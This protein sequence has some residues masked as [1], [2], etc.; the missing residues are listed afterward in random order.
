MIDIL[1]VLKLIALIQ[2]QMIDSVS[3]MLIFFR[4]CLG[5]LRQHE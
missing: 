5:F 2:I 1:L 4:E 3:L